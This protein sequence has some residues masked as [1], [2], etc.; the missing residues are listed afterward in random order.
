MYQL[1]D[2]GWPTEISGRI[3]CWT[4][5]EKYL[6]GATSTGKFRGGEELQIWDLIAQ[7]H[8]G[9]VPGSN[10]SILPGGGFI[11]QNET[12]IFATEDGQIRKLNWPETLRTIAIS[13]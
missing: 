8:A 9:R 3:I 11:R 4:A 13:K 12:L 7:R 5:D 1:S 6:I 10:K 2:K